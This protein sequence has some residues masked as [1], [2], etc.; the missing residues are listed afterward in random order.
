VI[1]AEVREVG[2][3][4][5][6]PAG[7]WGERALSLL[8]PAV[9]R[10]CGGEEASAPEGYVGR[11]CRTR[12]GA[13]RFVE[14]PFCGRCGLPFAGAIDAEFVCS[15]CRDLELHFEW[16]R[17]S[18]V[19]TPLVREVVHRYKYDRALWFEPFLAAL[20]VEGG[21]PVL[22]SGEWE[23]LVPV[24]LHPVK[25]REREFNQ[26][27]RLARHLGRATG[28]EVAPGLVRRV[29]ATRSQALLERRERVK[30]VARAFTVPDPTRV[31]GRRLVVVDDLFTTG[32]TTSAVSRALREAGAR[33]VV[34]WTLGRGL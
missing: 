20:L 2:T 17:A 28:L 24:P 15:N 25:L 13:V 27:E 10:I 3:A 33:S 32:A 6:P 34:V 22:G 31:A 5:A 8:Y 14:P 12:P 19:V 21:K 23:A 7:G 9:C 11:T 30:N 4:G 16:A 29:V 18:V 26:A 1:P